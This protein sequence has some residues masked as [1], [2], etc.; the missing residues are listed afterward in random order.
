MVRRTNKIG[1]KALDLFILIASLASI[2]ISIVGFIYIFFIMRVIHIKP[3]ILLIFVFFQG[4]TGF[5]I[6]RSEN[7]D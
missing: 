5:R 4:V 6:W 7:V 1:S 3:Y 2:L